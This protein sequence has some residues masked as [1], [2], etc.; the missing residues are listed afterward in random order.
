MTEHDE[1]LAWKAKKEKE[2]RE[3][4]AY[5]LTTEGR[6][7]LKDIFTDHDDGNSVRPL[8]DALE[9]AEV[10]IG[11]YKARLETLWE[12]LSEVQKHNLREYDYPAIKYWFDADG[13]AR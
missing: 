13:N 12:Y 1:F 10:Q 3:R 5:W 6:T 2:D 9:R 4:G 11:L 8:L 7:K